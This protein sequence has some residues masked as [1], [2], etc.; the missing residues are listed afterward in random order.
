MF[1]VAR[2][3]EVSQSSSQ[4]LNYKRIAKCVGQAHCMCLYNAVM[5][6]SHGV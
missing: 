3:C 4:N 6:N 5:P 1:A 2:K